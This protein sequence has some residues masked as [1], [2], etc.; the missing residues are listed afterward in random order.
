MYEEEEPFHGIPNLRPAPDTLTGKIRVY[1]QS[2]LDYVWDFVLA[3]LVPVLQ[4]I[5]FLGVIV[6]LSVIFNIYLRRVMVPKA[7]L[8]ERVYFNYVSDTPNAKIK[9]HVATQ[10]W[11]YVKEE[12]SV[13]P[14][15]IARRRFLK[16]DSYYNI[17]GVFTVAKS[18]RNYHIGASGLTTRTVDAS[19]ETAAESVRALIIPYQ[20]P[21]SLWL[22]SV[23]F[24]PYRV[25][26]YRAAETVDVYVDLINNYH[27]PG[28]ALPPTDSI[29]MYL[30]KPLLDMSHAYITV[31]PRLF[32]VV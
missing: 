11:N 32:G 15:R 24:F 30:N 19:N 21:V 27:E 14:S 31:M 26:T 28:Y 17:H 23:V 2:K 29:E 25:W 16:A 12:L 1:I 5:A 22:E 10:Q 20:H 4:L 18:A 7:L 3:A 13:D 6:V 8:H 9:L